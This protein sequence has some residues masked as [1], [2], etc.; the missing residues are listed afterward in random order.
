MVSSH[1]L[2]GLSQLVCFIARVGHVCFLILHFAWNQALLQFQ[3]F[4]CFSPFDFKSKR[5]TMMGNLQMWKMFKGAWWLQIELGVHLIRLAVQHNGPA[6]PIMGNEAFTLFV[7]ISQE[8]VFRKVEFCPIR[9][10]TQ[11]TENK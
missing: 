9:L 11:S 7:S 10:P 3:A 4:A 5:S 1:W 6:Q 2:E 8:L